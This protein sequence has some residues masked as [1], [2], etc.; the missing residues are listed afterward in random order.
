MLPG[1]VKAF[2]RRTL[3]QPF[4]ECA[5]YIRYYGLPEPLRTVRPYTMLST[6]N[7]YFL[8]ELTRRADRLGVLGDFVECGVYR[9]GSA[10]VL[11]YEAVR[12]TYQRRLWLYDSFAG[13]PVASRYDDDYSR[14]IEGKYIGSE[15][16]TRRILQRLRVPKE[17]FSIDVGWF[18]DTLPKSERFPIALLHVDCDFYNPVKLTLETFYS[19]VEPLGFIVLNDYGCF[20]GCRTATDEFLA[21]PGITAPLMQIDRDAYYFQKPSRVV[22]HKPQGERGDVA[23]RNSSTHRPPLSTYY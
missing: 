6:L 17:R 22:D 3:P 18:E 11:G 16:Q 1:L 10:G 21:K 5:D 7:L 12:S 15:T 2:F 14:S 8:Q 9:G 13:M 23:P 19:R 4:W 20:Q